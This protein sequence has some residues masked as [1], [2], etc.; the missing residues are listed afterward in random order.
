VS[1]QSFDA[2]VVGGGP[3]GIAA[4]LA[5]TEGGARALVVERSLYGDVR[6]GETFPPAIRRLLVRLNLWEDFTRAGYVPSVGI[7]SFWGSPDPY[8]QS[9]IFNPYG[10]G[11]H[12]DRRAF[13]AS[14]AQLA[15]VR[16]VQ[17]SPG[18]RLLA[19]APHESKGWML[20]VATRNNM[21]DVCA[22]F[23]LDATGRSSTL[24]R[25][26][27]AT[28]IAYDQLVAIFGFFRRATIDAPPE[29]FMLIEA[30]E[31]GWWYSVPLPDDSLVVMYMTDADLSSNVSARDAS[32]WKAQ[33]ERAPN[34][35]ARTASFTL[36]GEP[37]VTSASSSRLVPVFGKGWVAVG[38]AAAAY[39]PLS[40][41]GVCRA[42]FTGT[43]AAAAILAEQSGDNSA[44]LRYSETLE[45]EFEVY[46]RTREKFYS[47]EKRWPEAQFWKRRRGNPA[48]SAQLPG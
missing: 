26:L 6:I 28:R 38:D 24:A 29:P 20:R 17:L 19:C 32:H 4:A 36:I 42:L 33:L 39:D 48:P 27:G 9:F 35:L 47:L 10:T 25:R 8:E 44:L 7:R 2:V 14:I 41:D 31:N 15:S 16:G 21:L 12:V 45:N 13:D 37:R 5:L 3:A 1:P 30:A 43:H 23:V 22:R 34:T 18:S 46:L 11:W 40:G